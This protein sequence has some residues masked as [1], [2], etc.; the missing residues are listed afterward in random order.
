M[1]N[2]R[3]FW[4]LLLLVLL[5]SAAL[6][7]PAAAKPGKATPGF[8]VTVETV[9]EDGYPFSWVAGVGDPITYRVTVKGAGEEA[10]AVSDLLGTGLILTSGG[11]SEAYVFLSDPPHLVT[12]DEYSA[13]TNP[14]QLLHNEVT[15]TAGTVSKVV[16][17]DTEIHQWADCDGTFAVNNSYLM[18]RWTPDQLGYWAITV[19][20]D[21]LPSPLTFGVT[22]RDHIPGNFCVVPGGYGDIPEKETGRLSVRPPTEPIVLYVYLPE[23]GRCLEGG[24]GGDPMAAGNL[25][26]FYLMV[27]ASGEATGSFTMEFVFAPPA[28]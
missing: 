15:V 3:K 25:S 19:T 26:H 16:S 27:S 7:L 2:M 8:R 28:P 13:E 11:G 20:P 12:E 17:I 18:C 10:P 5:A 4:I 21:D 23:D 24:A 14:G 1:R 6:A 9:D 22:M